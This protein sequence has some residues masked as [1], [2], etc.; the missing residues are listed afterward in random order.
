MTNKRNPLTP[1][2]DE[3]ITISYQEESEI[4]FIDILNMI[5]EKKKLM[6]ITIFIITS[7]SIGYAYSKVNIYLTEIAFLPPKETIVPDALK[8]LKIAG[9]DEPP[10]Y[11]ETQE[12]LYFKFLTRIQSYA[13]QRQV[14]D[15]EGYLDRF[16]P[17]AT[18]STNTDELFL[19]IH[20]SISVKKESKTNKKGAIKQFEK[21]FYLSI[22]GSKPKVVSDFINSIAATARKEIKNEVINKVEIKLSNRLIRNEKNTHTYSFKLN[23]LKERHNLKKVRALEKIRTSIASK[24]NYL[25]E[26]FSDSLKISKSLNLEDNKFLNILGPER[27]STMPPP[28]GGM[29]SDVDDGVSGGFPKW[30]SYGARALNEEI[31][32][33]KLRAND[34]NFNDNL[35]KLLY[36]QENREALQNYEKKEEEFSNKIIQL[37]LERKYL[38]SI[39]PSLSNLKVVTISQPSTP[40]TFP[41]KPK[42]L[43]IVS[44]GFGIG[45]FVAFF[46]AVFSSGISILK[47]E[48]YANEG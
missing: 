16:A 2:A 29:R 22:E 28:P 20:N 43:K 39:N 13:Q 15:S 27:M 11:T 1:Q 40:P 25:I 18:D 42:R 10:L 38:K 26:T 36:E 31:K 37:K 4:K 3:N 46:F 9:I 33:L 19:V 8:D 7:L 14:F 35:S 48:K 34:K 12:S 47:K 41:I 23:N 21:S 17:G 32:R 44:V 5:V 45:L 30:F 6:L 24:R